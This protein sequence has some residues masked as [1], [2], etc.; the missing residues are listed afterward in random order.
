MCPSPVWAKL[1]AGGTFWQVF[2]GVIGK[3][4]PVAALLRTEEI[5]FLQSS[6]VPPRCQ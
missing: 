6:F 1:R 3:E 5:Q 2:S 4:F